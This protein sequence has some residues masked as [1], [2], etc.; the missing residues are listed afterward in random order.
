[1]IIKLLCFAYGPVMLLFLSQFHDHRHLAD[2]A[3]IVFFPVG[4][5]TGG[6]ILDAELCVGEIAAAFIAQGIKRTVAEQAVEVVGICTCV[7]GEIFA[8]FILKKRIVGHID[9]LKNS[10]HGKSV[11]GCFVK[12]RIS[13]VLGC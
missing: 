12:V 7:A 5:K 6:A 3:V 10:V 13:L 9:H 8:A 1:M 4:T 2:D 11:G